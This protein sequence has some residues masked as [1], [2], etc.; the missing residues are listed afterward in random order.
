MPEALKLSPGQRARFEKQFVAMLRRRWKAGAREYGDAS[1]FRPAPETVEQVLDEIAD[2][3]GWSFILWVQL[4]LRLD[5]ILQAA[6][7]IEV[8]TAE[9]TRPKAA[10]STRRTRP[11][12]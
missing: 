7:A 3:A 5:A 1:F 10:R 11:K 6:T 4:K 12:A 8:E 9:R 2:V